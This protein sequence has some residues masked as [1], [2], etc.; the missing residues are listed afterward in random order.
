MKVEILNPEEVKNILS[1]WSKMSC[2]CYDSTIKNPEAIGK[3]CLKSGHMSGGRTTYIMFKITDVGR[4][5]VDQIVRHEAGVVKNAQS[6]RYVNKDNFAY[7]IPDEIIDNEDL[8]QEYCDCMNHCMHIYSTIQSYVL[9]QGRTQERANEQARYVLPM[10]TKT[11]VCIG[12]TFEALEHFMNMRLCART[13]D[14]TRQIAQEMKKKVVEI[15]PWAEQYL[16]P[17]CQKNLWCPEGSQSC[18]A[19]PTKSRMIELLN[20]DQVKGQMT[21]TFDHYNR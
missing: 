11:S 3:H 20:S 9:S 4:K 13:E 1:D 14:R 21:L 15:I 2:V 17:N 16:V 8:V 12:F 18:G 7:D 19:Y 10:A 6:F 5:E